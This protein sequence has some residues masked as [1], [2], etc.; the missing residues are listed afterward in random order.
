MASSQGLDCVRPA[1]HLNSEKKV[2][3]APDQPSVVTLLPAS[4]PKQTT[5]A[6]TA[7]NTN[8]VAA[9][10]NAANAASIPLE[11]PTKARP[12]TGITGAPQPITVHPPVEK[13]STPA[14]T[15]NAPP[16]WPNLGFQRAVRVRSRQ[17][18]T[19]AKYDPNSNDI[20]MNR[21]KSLTVT[22]NP[23]STPP[24]GLSALNQKSARLGKNSTLRCQEMSLE[25]K[26]G[27]S[28]GSQGLKVK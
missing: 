22:A 25:N 16:L 13:P 23:Q 24:N 21:S 11:R 10:D 18:K 27:G 28:S 5:P 8:V 1:R 14:S 2:G 20:S 3:T 26:N 9:C 4:Q 15:P 19:S 6:A 12:T 17:W 7:M